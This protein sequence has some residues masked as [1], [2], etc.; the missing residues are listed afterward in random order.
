VYQILAMLFI[1]VTNTN[2][3]NLITELLIFVIAFL[4]APKV[5]A[6]V[7]IDIQL[8]KQKRASIEASTL[9]LN[10]QYEQVLS[11]IKELKSRKDLSLL[12]E[13]ELMRLLATAM[14][15]SNQ[16]DE[17]YKQIEEIESKLRKAGVENPGSKENLIRLRFAGEGI[18][19]GPAELKERA[20]ILKEK[21]DRLNSQIKRLEE[22]ERR[23]KLREEAQAFIKEQSLFDEDSSV[24]VVKKNIK[25]VAEDSASF[26]G[27]TTPK[28][29]AKN[30]SESSNNGIL[31]AGGDSSGSQ[32]TQ[33][34]NIRVRIEVT[35]EKSGVLN[36][37]ALNKG[38]SYILEIDPNNTNPEELNKQIEELK[39]IYNE[40]KRTR[41]ETE[42][43]LIEI[44]KAFKDRR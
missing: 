7:N 35:Y 12:E 28:G 6:Q 34:S 17:K 20:M 15:I 21:E 16:L 39:R 37:T 19:E 8:L 31:S 40:L 2:L 23:L 33:P 14:N 38:R 30:G 44:E 29:D 25:G 13:A 9:K 4:M 18:I 5:Y 1:I 32:S 43:R 22:I 11:R 42:K 10:T 3:K 24:S 27:N 41:S 36:Q 26:A